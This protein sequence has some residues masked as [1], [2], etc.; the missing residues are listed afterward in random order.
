MLGEGGRFGV[1]KGKTLLVRLE[2]TQ[3]AHP[4]SHMEDPVRQELLCENGGQPKLHRIS[5]G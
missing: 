2:A 4:L 1:R 3:S 5:F